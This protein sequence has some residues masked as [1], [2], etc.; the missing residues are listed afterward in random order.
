MDLPV[1]RI[2]RVCQMGDSVRDTNP[3]FR[4]ADFM[5]LVLTKNF[6]VSGMH[7]LAVAAK[8]GAYASLKK[9]FAMQ[10]DAA[11]DLV[12]ASG[13]RGRGGAGFPTGTKWGFVP[14]KSDKPRYLVINADESEPGTFK[15]R[16]ILERDPHLLIEGIVIAAYAIGAHRA[17][18]YFRGEYVRQWQRFIDAVEEARA[19]GLV[20]KNI[21]GSG[22]DLELFA[23]RGAG[24]YICGEETALLNS[25]EGRRGLPRIRPPFPAVEGLF[26]CPTVVNNVETLSSLPFILRE[27]VERFKKLGTERSAGT[28]LISVSGH[29]ARPG[30]YEVPMGMPLARFLDDCAG[31]MLGGRK[32]KAVIPGGSSVPV[33]TADEA[34]VANLDFES[35]AAAG[36]MLGSGGMIV[37]G[38]GACMVRVLSDLARFYAHESC[39]Q[40]TPCREGCGWISQICDRIESGRGRDGD[41]DEMLRLA[42]NMQGRTICVLADA[43]A[44]PVRSFVAKFRDEFDAHVRSGRCPC[45]QVESE[46]R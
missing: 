7:G 16:A 19:A 24:A 4:I 26:G 17:Y 2:A 37:I 20:G 32:L 44:M 34:L 9:L 6:G 36:S 10:P 23:H 18:A 14:K 29:V 31:G 35:I 40:C 45:A 27:G 13:L 46:E 11:I 21:A 42:D 39:G 33:L 1:M 43:L 5:E 30:V 15:D 25:I 22:F 8:H 41:V 28:K 12:K 3:V 38:D